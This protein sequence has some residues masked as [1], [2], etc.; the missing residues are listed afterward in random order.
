M[1]LKFK[2]LTLKHI[3]TQMRL[4]DWFVTMHLKDAYFDVSILPQ[5][6]KFLSFEGTTYQC[7]VLPFGLALSPHTFT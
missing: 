7:R 2:M 5:H 6:W 4:G 3:V 1:Q